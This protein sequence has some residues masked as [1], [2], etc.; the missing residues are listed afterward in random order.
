M[1]NVH[2]LYIYNLFQLKEFNK[3][4]NYIDEYDLFNNNIS[5]GILSILI[6]VYIELNNTHQLEYIINNYKLMKR[7]YLQLINYYYNKNIILAQQLWNNIDIVSIE[8]KDIDFIIKNNLI[9]LLNKLNNIFVKTSFNHNILL[10]ECN[11]DLILIYINEH[12]NNLYFNKLV[13]LINSNFIFTNNNIEYIIDAGN[14]LHS[15]YGQITKKSIDGLKQI[16]TNTKNNIVVIHKK[17]LKNI[18]IK[19]IINNC[20]HYITPYLYDDDI[21]ILL[22][23]FYLKSKCLII[24]NDNFKNYTYILKLQ[25]DYNILKQ[26]ILNYNINNYILN[27]NNN[28]SLCIHVCNNNIYIPTLTYNWYKISYK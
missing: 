9:L 12:N 11:K 13:N 3:L 19:N 23:F 8:T 28:F 7:D 24:S 22:I 21:Y 18:H 14:I 4:N 27:S 5:K 20:N 10:N 16:I 26:Q 2:E 6:L 15:T 17:H 25:N 1:K